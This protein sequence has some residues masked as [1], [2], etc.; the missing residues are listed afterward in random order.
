MNALIQ[1]RFDLASQG[2][3]EVCGEWKEPHLIMCRDCWQKHL[4]ELGEFT[5][6]DEPQAMTGGILW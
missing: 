2:Y 5:V 3:C 6:I 4:A 1:Q